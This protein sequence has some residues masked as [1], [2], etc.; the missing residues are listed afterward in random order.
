MN[1]TPGMLGF[2]ATPIDI[3]QKPGELG[4][5]KKDSFISSLLNN[6][7]NLGTQRNP[8]YTGFL[9]GSGTA[10]HSGAMSAFQ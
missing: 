3:G 1:F 6:N 7:G 5:Q 2:G 9:A 8:S 10:N 4:L